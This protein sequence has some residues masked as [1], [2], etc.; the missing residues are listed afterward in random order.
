MI[1]TSQ[2]T[3]GKLYAQGDGQ[4]GRFGSSRIIALTNGA[5]YQGVGGDNWER[6]IIHINYPV[7]AAVDDAIRYSIEGEIETHVFER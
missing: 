5:I 3:A 2:K 1:T 4:G 6:V 7:S